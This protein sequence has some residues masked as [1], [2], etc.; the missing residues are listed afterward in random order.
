MVG[1][2][3]KPENRKMQ[4]VSENETKFFLKIWKVGRLFRWNCEKLKFINFIIRSDFICSNISTK[5]P[6]LIF[7]QYLEEFKATDAMIDQMRGYKPAVLA[8]V[9]TRA[10]YESYIGLAILK[11]KKYTFQLKNA[12]ST[13]RAQEYVSLN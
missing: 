13:Q 9:A 11:E 7:L 12:V 2:L 4:K 5:S 1:T 6:D 3:G 8:R 10:S